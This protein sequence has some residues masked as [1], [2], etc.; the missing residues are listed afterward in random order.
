[1]KILLNTLEKLELITKG[2][3]KGCYKKNTAIYKLMDSCKG[4]GKQYLTNI[5]ALKKG[6]GLFCNHSCQSK[7]KNNS[8]YGKT[9]TKEAKKKQGVNSYNNP[10]KIKYWLDKGLT[11]HEAKKKLE[12]HNKTNSQYCIEYWLNKGFTKEESK[13]R[14]SEIQRK[15]G[16]KSR[17]NGSLIPTQ[18]EYW[19]SKGYTN[20]QA[21]EILSQ[22]Q[23]TF[24]KEICIKK[25]GKEKGLKI[26]K[27]R[28]SKWLSNF[29]RL[30]YSNI[31][32][33]LFWQIYLIIKNK[34]KEV[35]F[36][37]LGNRKGKDISGKN[38]EYKID[39]GDTYCKVDFFIK[40]INKIIEFDGDYWHGE[41]RGN[42][43]RD[44]QRDK[45]LNKRGYKVLH[46]K[47]RDY[48]QDKNKEIQR[49]MEFINEDS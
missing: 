31:S 4:C 14:I 45:K 13:K 40:D 17:I 38:Y 48:N 16:T 37:Q 25:Y 8:F 24:S 43:E 30:N 11:R 2:V 12:L 44:K 19:L 49:C 27:E 28:Q 21:K 29:K 22:R 15:N 32:Q 20:K 39:I 35:Y 33:E 9:H 18:L 3:N 26:W 6:I 47:E 42:I 10:S 34:Y 7:G 1:M 41:V 46:I 23:T 5:Y 36:A